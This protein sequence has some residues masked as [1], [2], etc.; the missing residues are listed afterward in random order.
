M[1][2]GVPAAVILPGVPQAT[3]PT[4]VALT[5]VPASLA[6]EFKPVMALHVPDAVNDAVDP[7]HRDTAETSG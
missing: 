5:A 7:A 6:P 1:A 4:P 3:V 2:N